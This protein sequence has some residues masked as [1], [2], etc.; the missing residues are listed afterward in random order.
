MKL[1]H[2]QIDKLQEKLGS[3][4]W[5]RPDPEHTENTHIHIDERITIT[6]ELALEINK[7]LDLI[8]MGSLL[9]TEPSVLQRLAYQFLQNSDT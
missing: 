2:T 6:P 8:E 1:D 7:E 3:P 9:G 5:F 4:E